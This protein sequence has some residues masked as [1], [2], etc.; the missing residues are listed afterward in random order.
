MVI[1]FILAKSKIKILDGTKEI[2]SSTM[3]NMLPQLNSLITEEISN[4]TGWANSIY[5]SN[6]L[7]T[8]MNLKHAVEWFY[9]LNGTEIATE[10]IN[11]L[12]NTVSE[13]ESFFIEDHD[14]ENYRS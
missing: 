8:E 10:S 7:L 3:R 5:K 12:N 9:F 4:I 13:L 6:W 2:V 11:R 1:L 14:L